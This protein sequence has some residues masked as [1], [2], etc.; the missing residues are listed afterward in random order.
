[1]TNLSNGTLLCFSFHDPQS[2]QKIMKA[3]H[4]VSHIN[5]VASI[6]WWKENKNEKS[7]EKGKAG[8]FK[9]CDSLIFPTK[10]FATS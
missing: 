3:L 5:K 4:Y 10:V 6:K 8:C 2:Y 9:A 7:L 1:M